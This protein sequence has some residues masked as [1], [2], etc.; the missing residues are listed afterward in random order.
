MIALTQKE[1]EALLIIYKDFTKFYNANSV[2]KVLG[3][4]QV[5]AM[6]LFKRL[7]KVNIV[8]SKRIGKSIIY[9][10]NLNEEISRKLLAFAL[11]NEAKKY[12]RW[13]NEF[14]SLYKEGRIILFYGSASRNYT[15]ARDIDIMVILEKEDIKEI[16]KKIKEI[17]EILPKKIHA[18][19]AT[20]D[21]LIKNLQTN[22]KAMIEIIR[23]A[24]ILYGYDDYMEVINGFAGF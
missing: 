21:D 3:I 7:E 13:I 17:Q 11:I 4:T 9:K 24:I 12:E 14:K 22:N 5:G 19:K 6:K 8:T 1:Q 2:S 20:K 23:T 15:Q 18:I 16:D 10:V